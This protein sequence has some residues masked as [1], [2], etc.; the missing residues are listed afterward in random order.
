MRP[1]RARPPGASPAARPPPRPPSQRTP[2]AP[3]AAACTPPAGGPRRP[4]RPTGAHPGGG[5]EAARSLGPA[6]L[7][8]FNKAR[9]LGTYRW[10]WDYAGG[11]VT[12]YG[13]HRFDSFRQ[14]MGV[15]APRSVVATG[16]RFSLKDSGETP[17]LVQATYE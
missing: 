14:V 11:W 5:W 2:S 8:P 1:R 17:D 16:G 12:D 3:R 13:T 6:P 4:A 7:V 9:F 10:F 15:D